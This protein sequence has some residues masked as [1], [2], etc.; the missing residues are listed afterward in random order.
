MQV[1][2]AVT[3]NPKLRK[4]SLCAVSTS[5]EAADLLGGWGLEVSL[6]ITGFDDLGPLEEV[7]RKAYAAGQRPAGPRPP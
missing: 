4:A 7:I 3:A 2:A 5:P 6:W 1:F